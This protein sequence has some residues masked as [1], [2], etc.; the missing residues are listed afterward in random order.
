MGTSLTRKGQK[1]DPRQLSLFDDLVE[2]QAGDGQ[3]TALVNNELPPT[4]IVMPTSLIHNWINEFQKFAPRFELYVHTGAQR[5]VP[6]TLRKRQKGF[7]SS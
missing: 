1:E 6:T 4:L 5:L 2:E 3:L 7:K